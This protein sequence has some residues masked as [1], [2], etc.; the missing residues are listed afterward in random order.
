MPPHIILLRVQAGCLTVSICV[1]L[2]VFHLLH[3]SSCK[4]ES[5]TRSM[6]DSG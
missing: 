1:L 3:I 2:V 4:L 5:R 6:D